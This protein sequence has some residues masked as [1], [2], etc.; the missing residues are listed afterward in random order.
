M[1]VYGE[2][3]KEFKT[4]RTFPKLLLVEVSVSDSDRVVFNAPGMETLYLNI[5]KL[6]KEH[7]Q[8]KVV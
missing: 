1:V 3:N 7:K 2:G 6:C 8:D 5:V 4:A